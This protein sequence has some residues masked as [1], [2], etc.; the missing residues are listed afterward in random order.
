M[1]SLKLANSPNSL[2]AATLIF[3]LLFNLSCATIP[4]TINKS[5]I[6]YKCSAKYLWGDLSVKLGEKGWLFL[7]D[8]MLLFFSNLNGKADIAVKLDHIKS[9]GSETERK[10]SIPRKS[11]LFLRES[12]RGSLYR[13]DLW[14]D[15]ILPL[16]IVIGV[17]FLGK[18]LI[19]AVTDYVELTVYYEED[20][21]IRWATFEIEEKSYIKIYEFLQKKLGF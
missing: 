20:S 11:N 2:V 1:R 12:P 13:T 17:F 7:V 8:D 3:S 9:Y 21:K 6:V 18:I 16:L 14:E 5:S 10:T 15:I 19:K 4:P